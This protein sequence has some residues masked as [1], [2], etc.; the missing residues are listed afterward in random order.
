MS[1]AS[2]GH[3]VRLLVNACA[4]VGQTIHSGG[5]SVWASGVTDVVT[6]CLV[7]SGRSSALY[8]IT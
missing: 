5:Q 3:C 6:D 4:V 7:N 1:K 8:V 2:G